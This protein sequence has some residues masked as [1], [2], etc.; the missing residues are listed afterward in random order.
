MTTSAFA[1]GRIQNDANSSSRFDLRRGPLVAI[2]LLLIVVSTTAAGTDPAVGARLQQLLEPGGGNRMFTA[3]DLG[4]SQLEQIAPDDGR[5]PYA[6]GLWLIDRHRYRDALDPIKQAVDKD[7]RNLAAWKTRIWLALAMQDYEDAFA[8]IRWLSERMPEP[9][10]T[11]RERRVREMSEF[12]GKVVGYLAGPG[13][14]QVSSSERA[15]FEEQLVTR[16]T[17]ERRSAFDAGRQQVLSDYDYR[18][19][20]IG[21]FRDAAR[22]KE[23]AYRNQRLAELELERQFVYDELAKLEQL[24]ITDRQTGSEERNVIAA[25]R[26]QVNQASVGSTT[27]RR[28]DDTKIGPHYR[29]PPADRPNDRIVLDYRRQRDRQFGLGSGYANR[30]SSQRGLGDRHYLNV[31]ERQED[32][33]DYLADREQDLQ[34]RL[35]RIVKDETALHRRPNP[36]SDTMISRAMATAQ[37]MSTYVAVPVNPRVELQR[38]LDSY[39]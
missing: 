36:G 2:G 12:F 22:D 27:I 21:N 13:Q 7:P 4:F 26:E 35:R 33:D 25:T 5:V 39:V 15:Y 19:R 37:A 11:T 31:N 1:S 8:T 18:M 6:R 10:S 38:I 17:P 9:D 14:Q 3:R 34:L 30:F 24:R 23:D 29:K 32:Y 28:S 20:S 16:F